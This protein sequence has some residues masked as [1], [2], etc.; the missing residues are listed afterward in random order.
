MADVLRSSWQ[1]CR[2]LMEDLT[3]ELVPRVQELYES[4]QYMGGWDGN[5]D[6]EQ[7]HIMNW[8][9]EGD[10]P[11]NGVKENYKIQTIRHSECNAIIGYITFYHGFPN[12]DIVYIPFL[13]I[14]PAFQQQGYA[15]EAVK[16]LLVE[17]K[18]LSYRAIRLNVALKNW[19]ALRFWIKTGF[20]AITGIH[21]DR[22]FAA[23]AYANLELEQILLK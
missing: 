12:E 22:A 3:M 18:G 21:G 17:L 13:F 19:P 2:L 5:S 15:E 7:D 8:Y 1:T 16:G 11:P 9:L 4:S 6:R 20:T 10:L 14:D 23:D